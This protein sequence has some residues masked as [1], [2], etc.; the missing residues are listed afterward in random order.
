MQVGAGTPTST[1]YDGADR[2]LAVGSTSY[3]WDAA[4][5]LT[6]VGSSR[7]CDTSVHNYWAAQAASDYQYRTQYGSGA[8]DFPIPKPVPA[9]PRP[10]PVYRV[11]L[12]GRGSARICVR[13]CSSGGSLT[14]AAGVVGIGIVTTAGIAFTAATLGA[15][16]EAAGAADAF[17]AKESGLI[18]ESA[19]PAADDAGVV[20]RSDPSHIFRDAAGHLAEDT[21][22][23]RSLIRGAVQQENLIGTRTIGSEVLQSY[24]QML[25]DGRQ[26]WVEVRNGTEI[27]NGGVNSVPKP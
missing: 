19:G 23:N 27:A 12:A 4:D 9:A 8:I 5:E 26:V 17:I 13:N 16:D 18:G 7:T 25:P 14:Q 22:A 2:V 15:S 10:K 1:T 20:F 21:P 6:N 11:V 3:T 24:Q